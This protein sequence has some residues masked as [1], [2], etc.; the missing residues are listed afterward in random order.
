ML[1]WPK[2][3][4]LLVRRLVYKDRHKDSLRLPKMPWQGHLAWLQPP[5]PRSRQA[6]LAGS[7]SGSYCQLLAAAAGKAGLQHAWPMLAQALSVLL[8]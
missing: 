5:R 4:N 7:G 8:A 1:A 3:T 2:A 6:G